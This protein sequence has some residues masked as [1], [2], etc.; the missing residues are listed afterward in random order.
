MPSSQQIRETMERYVKLMSAGD[1]DGIAA[2]Y[3][4][5]ATLE[6]PIGA[7]LVRGKAA[8]LDWYR[9]S[10]GKVKLDD[11]RPRARLRPRGRDPA[12]G[13]RPG[14]PRQAHADRHHRRDEL[15]RGRA[16]R[17]DAR[18]LE[19]RCDPGGGR[20]EDGGAEGDRTPDLV[21]AIHALSQLSYSPTGRGSYPERPVPQDRGC[22]RGLRAVRYRAS[23]VPRSEPQA[24]E[25]AVGMLRPAP[26][27]RNRQTQGTQNPPAR[28]GRVGS[29]PTSGTAPSH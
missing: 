3:R 14:R 16:H 10:A 11:H 5:D 6:D 20:L 23:G 9:K 29:T 2:L 28:K 26:E 8:I 1:A 7:P 24:S 22:A 19:C 12:P 18:V 13:P 27:W 15:R 17:V 25:E 21:N 4:D